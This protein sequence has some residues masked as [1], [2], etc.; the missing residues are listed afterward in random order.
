VNSA[1]FAITEFYEVRTLPDA[2]FVLWSTYTTL[3]QEY[4][5]F[6]T[7]PAEAA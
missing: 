3:R 7:W 5:A 4:D 1:N 6:V 2:S